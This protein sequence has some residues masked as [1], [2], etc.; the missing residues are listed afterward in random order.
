[1][2]RDL[3]NEIREGFEVLAKNR[4]GIPESAYIIPDVATSYAAVWVDEENLC[5]QLLKSKQ[6]VIFLDK[7]F[8]PHLVDVLI[9]LQ[10]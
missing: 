8:I 4:L 2:K 10:N 5:I 6:D 3:T 7:K 1:M 9:E